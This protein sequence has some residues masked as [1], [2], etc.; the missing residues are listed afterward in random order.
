[1]VAHWSKSSRD[2]KRCLSTS[3]KKPFPRRVRPIEYVLPPVDC[4][5]CWDAAWKHKPWKNHPQSCVLHTNRSVQA[6]CLVLIC[7]TEEALSFRVERKSESALFNKL[8]NH[9][10]AAHLLFTVR[11][12]ASVGSTIVYLCTMTTLLLLTADKEGKAFTGC[13]RRAGCSYSWNHSYICLY[14]PIPDVSPRGWLSRHCHF[15]TRSS[16]HLLIN[17]FAEWKSGWSL[18]V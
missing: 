5:I 10:R 14:H 13:C 15:S 18:P 17:L 11:L 2:G 7:I 4:R 16:M 6:L 9:Q 12:G 3:Q 1:M 8:V